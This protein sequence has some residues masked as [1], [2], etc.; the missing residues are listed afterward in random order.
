M[1]N[2]ATLFSEQNL[3]NLNKESPTPLYFQLYSLLKARI[4]DGTLPFGQRMPTEEEL[5]ATFGV[6]RITAKR[7]M[8]ELAGEAL[9][10]RRR[11][12]GTHI[13]YHYSPRP[14]QAP[15]TGMLQEIESM[16]RNS[17]AQV[18]ECK[19]LQPPQNVREELA[20]E[21]GE[22]ALHLVRVREREGRRFGYYV[23][24]TAGVK[25]PRSR[26]IFER[27][28]RLTYFRDNGLEVTHVTQTLSAEAASPEVAAA[29]EV[30]EGSP[31]LSLVRRSYNQVGDREHLCDHLRAL[32]NPEHFQ[33]KM[34]LKID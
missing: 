11:G 15:L 33:Y 25:M 10:E 9:V 22:P 14:V 24:W 28:P 13:T 3:E 27:T 29:L 2:T 32:Y 6:S 18:L 34:D 19:M 23:S 20:L 1:S 26:K 21:T 5:A 16:A 17:S 12:K 8:D 7:A 31:L 30:P 4:L